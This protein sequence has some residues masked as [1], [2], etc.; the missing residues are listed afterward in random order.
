MPK[1]R[2]LCQQWDSMSKA[3]RRKT[4]KAHTLRS[5]NGAT[6]V[7]RVLPPLPLY[8]AEISTLGRSVRAS[9]TRDP[10]PSLGGLPLDA[11]AMAVSDAPREGNWSA[12]AGAHRGKPTTGA[13][14]G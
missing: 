3:A 1:D 11:E 6:A 9:A 7:G 8:S 4:P 13:L 12:C 5:E 2:L 10:Q 14:S